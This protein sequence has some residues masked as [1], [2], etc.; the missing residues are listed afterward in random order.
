MNVNASSIRCQQPSGYVWWDDLHGLAED[1]KPG[2]FIKTSHPTVME[3]DGNSSSG[4]SV[5]LACLKLRLLSSVRGKNVCD[6]VLKQRADG[7]GF[8]WNTKRGRRYG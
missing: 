7:G 6:P 3:H 8:P 1:K 2:I 5:A 4:A